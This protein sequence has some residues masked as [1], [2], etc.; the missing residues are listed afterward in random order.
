MSDAITLKYEDLGSW[1]S[2]ATP[3]TM[4]W[5]GFKDRSHR[6]LRGD[7][8]LC[9]AGVLYNRNYVAAE[10]DLD[11][12]RAAADALEASLFE[13]DGNAVDLQEIEALNSL[14]SASYRGFAF[15]A[16][17]ADYDPDVRGVAARLYAEAALNDMSGSD[18]EF[19][20]ALAESAQPLVRLGLV[21]GLEETTKNHELLRQLAEDTHPRVRMEA[22]RLQASI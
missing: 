17:S 4:R 1:D 2:E 16:L 14:G 19:F 13:D 22:K 20:T 6:F 9:D 15:L 12:L 3:L 18:G 8:E 21:Y 10:S 5:K 11:G 7:Q